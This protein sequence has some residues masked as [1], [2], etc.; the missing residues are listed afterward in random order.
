MDTITN[1]AM[2]IASPGTTS[3]TQGSTS[4]FAMSTRGCTFAARTAGDL[5]GQRWIDGTDLTIDPSATVRE[6]KVSVEGHVGLIAYTPEFH[7]WSP[8]LC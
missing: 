6:R 1:A 5:A 7:A 4:A 8:S 2:T 3:T